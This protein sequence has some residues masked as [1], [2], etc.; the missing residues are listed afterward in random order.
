MNVCYFEQFISNDL[1]DRREK[2]RRGRK[3]LALGFV[4][5]FGI[6]EIVGE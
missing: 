3:A 4:A 5:S 6:C 1:K 2:V